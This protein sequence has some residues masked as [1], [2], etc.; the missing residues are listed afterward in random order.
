[1]ADVYWIKHQGTHFNKICFKI[2]ISQK[3]LK[4]SAYSDIHLLK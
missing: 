3:H 2:L 1:M 4:M